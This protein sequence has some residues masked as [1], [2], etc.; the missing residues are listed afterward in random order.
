MVWRA[1]PKYVKY[2]EEQIHIYKREKHTTRSI[3]MIS[4]ILINRSIDNSAKPFSFSFTR[5]KVSRYLEHR[6]I[7]AAWSCADDGG[8]WLQETTGESLSSRRLYQEQYKERGWIRLTLNKAS[9][10]STI[11]FLRYSS[12]NKSNKHSIQLALCKIATLP[13]SDIVA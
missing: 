8:N 1:V 5:L 12:W 11:C 13:I 10:C 2:W 4:L 6:C 7:F 3:I 9:T